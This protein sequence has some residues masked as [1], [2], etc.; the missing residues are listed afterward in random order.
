MPSTRHKSFGLTY[1]QGFKQGWKGVFEGFG[2][3]WIDDSWY[4]VQIKHGANG[5]QIAYRVD[6][7]P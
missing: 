2:A 4:M 6:V 7:T 5:H 3:D 1:G